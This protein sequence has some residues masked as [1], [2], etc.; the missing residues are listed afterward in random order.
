MPENLKEL[1]ADC[2]S[3]VYMVGGYVRNAIAGLGCTDIDLAGPEVSTALKLPKGATAK[4]VNFRLGTAIISY[5]GKKYEYTPFR[6]EKYAQ[7]GGHTPI[8][9]KFTS[10]LYAD[11]L[12][13][14][15]TVN[16]IYYDIKTNEII[17]PFNG[18]LDINNKLIR[19]HDPEKIFSSDGLRILRLVRIAAETGFK[20]DS[21]TASSAMEKLD[22]LADISA[23]RKAGELMRIL[24]ADRK[25]GVENAH[26]RGL[27]LCA[28]LGIFKY[29]LPC[30]AETEGVEQNP[31]YHKF[32]VLEHTL[33]CVKHAPVNVRLAALMHDVGKPVSLKLYGNMHGHERLSALITQN[34]LG[35]RG[36]K[37]PTAVVEETAR[38]CQN[39]M[40]DLNGQTSESKV[41]IFVARNFDIID[42]LVELIKADGIATGMDYD[43]ADTEHR[44]TRIKN[45][46]IAN[47]APLKIAD[48]KI[49]G[50][51]L[52]QIGFSGERIGEILDEMLRECIINPRLNNYEW[53]TEFAKRRYK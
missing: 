48:L 51:V 5:K 47:F 34:A 14:D 45:E 12:R 20:I 15:F 9:V 44:F 42:K 43:V 26:Y 18:I 41:K 40:Y 29:L 13:R 49:S 33:R 3:K 31:K 28:K 16:S 37:F 22:Y 11:A 50:D 1:F 21:L 24:Q 30:V 38:L 35:Q 23:E 6:M 17:D 36:L 7:G 32:D 46:L 53:L 8:E 2:N 19:S 27:K 39:H 10:D 25:Y 52:V 4:I